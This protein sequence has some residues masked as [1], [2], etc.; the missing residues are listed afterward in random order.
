MPSLALILAPT[1]E[2]GNAPVLH[3]CIQ[4]HISLLLLGDLTDFFFGW[5]LCDYNNFQGAIGHF[6]GV[7]RAVEAIFI[8]SFSVFEPYTK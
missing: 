4:M 7:A 1:P 8:F 2:F 6:L 3:R 5:F